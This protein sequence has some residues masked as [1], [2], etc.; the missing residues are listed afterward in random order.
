VYRLFSS[1]LGILQ[2]LL[3]VS[4]AGDDQAVAPADRP[5]VRT[6]LAAPEPWRQLSSFARLTGS[7]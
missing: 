5:E 2:A 1:K 6:L 4:I 3:D 7:L